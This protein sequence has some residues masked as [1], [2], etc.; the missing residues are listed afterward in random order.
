MQV[1]TIGWGK[2]KGPTVRLT[3]RGAAPEGQGCSCSCPLLLD[4]LTDPRCPGPSAVSETLEGCVPP[5]PR[6]CRGLGC[7]RVFI[8]AAL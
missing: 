3:R 2:I 8:G 7:L 4:T 6:V 5:R 1:R